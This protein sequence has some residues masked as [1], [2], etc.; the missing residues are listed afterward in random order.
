MLAHAGR[1]IRNQK[2]TRRQWHI[3]VKKIPT[4]C[5]LPNHMDTSKF[6]HSL[7]IP[8][9]CVLSMCVLCVSNCANTHAHMHVW[10]HA[11]KCIL[12]CMCT[13]VSTHANVHPCIQPRR[14]ALAGKPSRSRG[15]IMWL[16]V[17]LGVPQV[18]VS[19]PGVCKS[20]D[21]K[22]PSNIWRRGEYWGWKIGWIKNGAEIFSISG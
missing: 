9:F 8:H 22:G 4:T 7:L 3:V 1:D 12:M 11:R 16:A 6:T 20:E 17:G 10:M 2:P 5:Y 14:H 15:H 19:G 13:C 18:W 21:N